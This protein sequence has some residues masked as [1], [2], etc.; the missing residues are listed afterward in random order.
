MVS[1]ELEGEE[2]LFEVDGQLSLD[3]TEQER[4]D[5]IEDGGV[6]EAENSSLNED[7]MT[8]IDGNPIAV[9]TDVTA[10]LRPKQISGI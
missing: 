10:I 5:T 7:T 8:D 9:L 2:E 1:D 6:G 3:D 4:G